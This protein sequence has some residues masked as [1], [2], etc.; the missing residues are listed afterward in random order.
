[1]TATT[2]SAAIMGIAIPDFNPASLA[3]RALEKSDSAVISELQM[4]R[5]ADQLLPGSTTPGRIVVRSLARR[6]TLRIE[7][8]PCHAEL[9]SRA[10]ASGRGTQ[11]WPKTQPVASHTLFTTAPKAAFK[12]SAPL[13]ER[14]MV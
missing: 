4:G 9:H 8:L 13:T 14:A 11:A 1:M 10:E 5:L 3:E 7:L 2:S 6:N 12:S